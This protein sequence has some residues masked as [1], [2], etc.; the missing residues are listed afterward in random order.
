MDFGLRF[1]QSSLKIHAPLDLTNPLWQR[2]I[3]GQSGVFGNLPNAHLANPILH[4]ISG[5]SV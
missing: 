4:P 5:Q 1:G 3:F 2:H